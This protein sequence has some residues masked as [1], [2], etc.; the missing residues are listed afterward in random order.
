MNRVLLFRLAHT[1][2][3]SRTSFTFDLDCDKYVIP[4]TLTLWQP[5]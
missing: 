3:Q 4:K 2:A 5:E 1:H